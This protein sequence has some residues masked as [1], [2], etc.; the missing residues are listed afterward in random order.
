MAELRGG[1]GV[2]GGRPPE[3]ERPEEARPALAALR[4]EAADRE[5]RA[6]VAADRAD[7]AER[8]RLV[9]G[10]LRAGGRAVL[11]LAALERAAGR[12]RGVEGSAA[13]GLATGAAEAVEEAGAAA[14]GVAAGEGVAGLAAGAVAAAGTDAAGGAS[15][16]AAGG[17]GEAA[18]PGEELE[19]VMVGAAGE[20]VR[21]GAA[22]GPAAPLAAAGLA[23]LA[24]RRERVRRE[25]GLAMAERIGRLQRRG[26]TSRLAPRNR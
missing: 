14:D 19:D 9:R 11:A 23:V 17:L 21:E 2:A 8:A 18:G 16:G 1:V 15:A 6:G 4:L 20:G 24:L 5:D 26:G 7:V 25:E 12:A 10:V 13:A 3:A 22:P